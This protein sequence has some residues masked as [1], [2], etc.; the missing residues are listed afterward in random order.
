MTIRTILKLMSTNLKAE[1]VEGLAMTVVF[2]FTDIDEG[3]SCHL[4][5]CVLDIVEGESEKYDLKITTTS[6]TW[7]EIISQERNV[8]TAYMYMTGDIAIDGGL[9]LMKQFFDYFDQSNFK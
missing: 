6:G 3:Y 9:M 1:S 4:R 7:R 2:N 8:V 5:N